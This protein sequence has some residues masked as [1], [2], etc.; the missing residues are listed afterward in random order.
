MAWGCVLLI[1]PTLQT[2]FAD[3]TKVFSSSH[4]QTPRYISHWN[5]GE[6]AVGL[7]GEWFHK[8]R[9]E[10]LPDVSD[11]WMTLFINTTTCEIRCRLNDA[12]EI[13]LTRHSRWGNVMSPIYDFYTIVHLH[14]IYTTFYCHLRTTINAKPGLEL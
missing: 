7:R 14:V 2:T 8:E 10:V 9:V 12:G 5:G 3:P 13:M 6:T 11:W 4:H 1:Q